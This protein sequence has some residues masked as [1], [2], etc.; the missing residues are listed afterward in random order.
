[1]PVETQADQVK[2]DPYKEVASG[3]EAAFNLL[4]QGREAAFAA[5]VAA[6]EAEAEVLTQESASIEEAAQ[7]LEL[8]LP[9]KARLSQFE[10][11]Q[12]TLAGKHEEA[13]AK[14]KEAEA[15]ARAPEE[16][17]TRQAAITSRLETVDGE[18][19]AIA[20]K[21][22]DGWYSELLPLIRSYETALFIHLLESAS[23]EM[24]SF[25]SKH[26][27]GGTL[28]DPYGGLVKDSHLTGLTAGER[29]REWTLGHHWYGGRTR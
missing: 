11:D 18:R 24:Y 17:R 10:A 14:I 15:A 5:G 25:Q 13:R 9:A 27:L 21:I 29:T 12:L 16:M 6:L 26:D 28:S 22:F 23:D 7:N 4:A 19:R 2:V 3:A 1:M 20:R 8:I